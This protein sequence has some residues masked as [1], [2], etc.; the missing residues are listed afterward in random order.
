MGYELLVTPETY[1]FLQDRQIPCTL[2]HFPDSKQEPNIKKM[3]SNEEVDMVVNL[4][5]SASTELENNFATRRAAVDFGVPLLNNAQ[6][7]KMFVE[8]L[9]KHKAG[10]IQF[11]E[12]ENLFDYYSKESVDEAWSDGKE[13]H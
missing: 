10:K 1:A 12:A 4:P 7:F 8:A 11:T 5:T 9:E 13:F 6:L 2:V 3:I